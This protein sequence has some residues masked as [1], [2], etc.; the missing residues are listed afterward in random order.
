MPDEPIVTEDGLVGFFAALAQAIREFESSDLAPN[1]FRER[2]DYLVQRAVYPADQEP[3]I[4][5]AESIRNLHQI[6]IVLLDR[7]DPILL[8]PNASQ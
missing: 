8:D 1:D 3:T 5:D 2:L 4:K 7:E 6:L